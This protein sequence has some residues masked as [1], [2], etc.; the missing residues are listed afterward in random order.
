MKKV[1]FSKWKGVFVW[2][3]GAVNIIAFAV[4]GGYALVKEEDKSVRKTAKTALFVTLVFI[5][6][7]AVLALFGY[8]GGMFDGYYQS[9]PWKICDILDRLTNIARLCVYGFFIIMTFFSKQ[10]PEILE[11]GEKEEKTEDKNTD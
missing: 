8:I 6:I 10:T 2:L 11:E 3:C 1:D 5:A 7:K 9:V 4:V